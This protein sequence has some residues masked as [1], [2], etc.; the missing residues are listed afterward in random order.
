MEIIYKITSPSGKF[1]IGRTKD[2]DLRMIQHKS[3][4]KNKKLKSKLYDAIRKYGWE[5]MVCEIIDKAPTEKIKELEESYILKYN[6]I[7]EGYNLTINTADGGNVWEGREDTPEYKE[8]VEL[9]KEV[10]SGEKNGM[11]GKTHSEETKAKMKEKAAGRCS[12]EWFINKHG[13]AE[14]T[15]RYESMMEKRK[16]NR[17]DKMKTDAAGKF[18][19]A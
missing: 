5:N 18:V 14:G 4:S 19:K 12:L 9:M 13:I 15:Q 10:T 7:N 2:F 6:T 8:F 3:N 16:K 1:Y 17:Y 11:F